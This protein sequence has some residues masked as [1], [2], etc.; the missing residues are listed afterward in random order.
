MVVGAPSVGVG[1]VVG[2]V[3]VGDLEEV[4]VVVSFCLFFVFFVF[5]GIFRTRSYHSNGLPPP[6][7]LGNLSWHSFSNA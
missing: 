7:K 1:V 5:M 6:P 3:D 2:A 4:V